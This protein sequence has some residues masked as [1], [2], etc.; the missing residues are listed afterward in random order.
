MRLHEPKAALT[1]GDGLEFYRIIVHD[2]P[3]FLSSGGAL[4][5]EIGASQAAE[6]A[7]MLVHAEFLDVTHKQGLCR[8]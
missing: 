4:V 1:A 6:V 2:A 5:L 3:A 7:A 8:T